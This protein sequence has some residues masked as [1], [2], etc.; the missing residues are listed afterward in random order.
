M[1]VS[2]MKGARGLGNL[3]DETTNVMQCTA[4][5]EAFSVPHAKLAAEAVLAGELELQ[6][7]RQLLSR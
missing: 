2:Q 7:Y 6:L 4:A 1:K 5:L 3:S